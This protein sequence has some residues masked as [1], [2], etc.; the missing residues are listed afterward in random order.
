[1]WQHLRAFVTE[2]G[3]GVAFVAGPRFLPWRYQDNPDLRA[4]L[5]VELEGLDR[6]FGNELPDEASRG[7]AV[8]PTAVG[9]LSPTMQLGDSTS[10]S[11]RLWQELA[12]QFWLAPFASL[13]PAAQVLATASAA[14]REVADSLGRAAGRAS[15]PLIVFQF[16]GAGRVLLH[17]I[18]ST[19]LWRRGIGETVFA[20]YWVQTV[21]YLARGK[22]T[23]GRGIQLRTDRR[24]YRRGEPVQVRARFFDPRLAPAAGEVTVSITGRGRPRQ[25]VSLRRNAAAE[26]IF[27]G[28]MTELPEGSYQALL[29]EPQSPGEPPEARFAVISPPGEFARP[30]MDRAALT[31]AAEATGGRFYTMD[32]ADRLID[33]LPPGRRV[34]LENLP[35]VSIW[36]RW[37]L[38]AMFLICLT[39]EWVLRKQKGML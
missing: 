8:R 3:G 36:N 32:D 37:W 1:V 20:R 29:T 30:E 23:A 9:R 14:P 7:F 11:E 24:E 31:A 38:L 5:P 33:E 17:A 27:D 35:P 21:R 10:A 22:L 15:R 18:D 4:L 34:P 25:Q 16:V 12:P 2:K 26:G 6:S 13:K 19:W 39:C 28:T